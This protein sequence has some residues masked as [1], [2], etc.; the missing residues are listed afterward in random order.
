MT[1][2]GARVCIL[3]MS[4]AL[5][6]AGTVARPVDDVRERQMTQEY[7]IDGFQAWAAAKQHGFTFQP[8]AHAPGQ[9][10]TNPRDGVQTLLLAPAQ[11]GQAEDT[12]VA[13]AQ[14]AA[15]SASVSRPAI[16]TRA[17]SFQFFANRQLARSWSVVRVDLSGS[18]RWDQPVT[19]GSRDLS[20]RVT[21]V[22]TPSTTGSVVIRSVR[23][24]GP[25]GVN[26]HDAFSQAEAPP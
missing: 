17:V 4:L 15:G 3:T 2:R 14:V 19:T 22:S 10:V 12:P 26:W 18:F 25:A 9:R 23:L 5:L 16:G 11:V 6:A 21:T 13:L 7:A 1:S 8:L 24:R 20:F